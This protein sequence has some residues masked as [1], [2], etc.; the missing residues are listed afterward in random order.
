M[1]KSDPID[2]SL[3]LLIFVVVAMFIYSILMEKVKEEEFRKNTEVFPPVRTYAELNTPFKK[4]DVPH[5]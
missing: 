1:T 2:R 5:E 3:S 4:Q